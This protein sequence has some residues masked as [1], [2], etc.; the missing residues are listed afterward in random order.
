M[1]TGNSG[2]DAAGEIDMVVFEQN[3]IEKSDTVIYTSP[4]THCLF[5]EYAHTR[6]C[7]AG[8]KHPGMQTL[9]TRH[10]FMG[11]GSDTAHTL[12]DIEHRTLGL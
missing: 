11:N 4:Y 10:V 6:R 5:F 8:I 3:H 9:E 1:A 7:L 12:H 2:F